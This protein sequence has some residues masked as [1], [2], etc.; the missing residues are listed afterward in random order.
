MLPLTFRG[1]PML[2]AHRLRRPSVPP[3]YRNN[4]NVSISKTPCHADFSKSETA[5]RVPLPI[6]CRPPK[7]RPISAAGRLGQIGFNGLISLR[8][9][10]QTGQFLE[11]KTHFSAVGRG[12]ATGSSSSGPGRE[13]SGSGLPGLA[14]RQGYVRLAQITRRTKRQEPFRRTRGAR[15]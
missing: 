11:A 1:T 2:A 6:R 7:S 8:F 9:L 14:R 5:G 4:A 15:A 10:I 13:V 12:I 3:T